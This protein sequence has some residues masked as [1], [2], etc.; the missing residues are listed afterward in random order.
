QN[1]WFNPS[2]GLN[3]NPYQVV[4]IGGTNV[5]VI[6]AG[7]ANCGDVDKQEPAKN[8]AAV[9]VTNTTDKVGFIYFGMSLIVTSAPASPATWDFT[10]LSFPN[11]PDNVT[12]NEERTSVSDAGG[13]TYRWNTHV[14]GLDS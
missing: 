13:G 10:I 7:V 14:N 11:L 3:N 1:N 12:H 2:P 4:N 6:P 8:I 9:R 5:L